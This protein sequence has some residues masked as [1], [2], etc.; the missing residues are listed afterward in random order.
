MKEHP[1][2]WYPEQGGHRVLVLYEGGA[3]DSATFHLEEE[4]WD[5]EHCDVCGGQIAAMELCQVT[6]RGP[7]IALCANCYRRH[8]LGKI[9]Y[10]LLKILRI[11]VP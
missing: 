11:R 6:S 2:R 10:W 8:V 4:S 9:R 1:A 7:Y 3:Y 5:H